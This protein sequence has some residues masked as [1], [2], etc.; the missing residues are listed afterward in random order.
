MLTGP[1]PK[2][3]GTRD[4]LAARADSNCCSTCCHRLWHRGYRWLTTRGAVTGR[5]LSGADIC[6]RT[7]DPVQF[8][9]N[10]AREHL[11][12]RDHVAVG[13]ST[14]VEETNDVLD[15]GLFGKSA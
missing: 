12:C 9:H 4:I 3:Y 10:V 13:S 1:P 5:S 2:F 14:D 6:E 7:L 15:P 11:H 8:G